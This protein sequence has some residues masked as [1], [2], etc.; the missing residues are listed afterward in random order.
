MSL[1]EAG[2]QQSTVTKFHLGKE[3]PTEK[4][5]FKGVLTYAGAPLIS[6]NHHTQE[7]NILSRGSSGGSWSSSRVALCSRPLLGIALV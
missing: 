5:D 7:Q 3:L 1:L 4:G 2:F 6:L